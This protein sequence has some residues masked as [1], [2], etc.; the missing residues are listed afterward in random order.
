MFIKRPSRDG[1]T[2]CPVFAVPADVAHL[3]VNLLDGLFHLM[4]VAV[5]V[6]EMLA[7]ALSKF[8]QHN[9]AF[10]ERSLHDPNVVQK[11]EDD[12]R[13]DDD[14]N[15]AD[16]DG[17][18]L[19]DEYFIHGVMNPQLPLLKRLDTFP[20]GGPVQ[21]DDLE[22]IPRFPSLPLDGG[23]KGSGNFHPSL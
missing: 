9:P 4:G 19:N 21:S 16:R 14:H 15:D 20:T 10:R 17:H 18:D 7:D 1:Q 6:F 8:L 5:H 12:D 3:N 23:G 2:S 11:Q 13:F 22:N